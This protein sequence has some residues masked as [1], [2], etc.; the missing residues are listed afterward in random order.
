M[1]LRRLGIG[2][3]VAACAAVIVAQ[4]QP[5]FRPPPGYVP[6]GMNVGATQTV[7]SSRPGELDVGLFVQK[8]ETANNEAFPLVVE[9]TNG[10]DATVSFPSR[11]YFEYKFDDP[12]VPPPPPFAPTTA[13]NDGVMV[14]VRLTVPYKVGMTL[15]RPALRMFRFKVT[16]D[17]GGTPDTASQQTATSVLLAK[18][19][20]MI[21]RFDLTAGM[22]KP[23][24]DKL[25]VVLEQHG[26]EIA[27]SAQIEVHCA[28]LAPEPKPSEQF[29]GGTLN[30][31][32]RP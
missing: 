22:L 11:I 8:M 28:A 19:G 18:K 20:N 2:L 6:P 14:V 4:T 9:I 31:Q 24:V 17:A 12:N 5:V 26:K 7:P 29:G 27:H 23:G 30:T 13:P 10:T 15:G 32:P 3:A 21:G 1:Q 16:P 25:E